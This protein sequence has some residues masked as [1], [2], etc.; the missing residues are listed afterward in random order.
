MATNTVNYAPQGP[1]NTLG[2]YKNYMREFNEKYYA[3]N[4]YMGQTSNIS[5][6]DAAMQG[7]DAAALQAS[8]AYNDRAA[9][10]RDQSAAWMKMLTPVQQSQYWQLNREQKA[11][12]KRYGQLAAA[13][14]FAAIGGLG[15]LGGAGGGA[16]GVGAGGLDTLAGADIAG[17]LIPEFGSSAAYTAGLGGTGAVGGA[18]PWDSFLK[19][20]TSPIGNMATKAGGS[21]L[22]Q[23]I[24]GGGNAYMGNKQAGQY[25]DVISQINQLFAPDS[26]YAKQMQ[27]TLARKD[28]AAGRNSQY[29]DRAVQLA[30]ALTQAKSN[31][32]TSPGYGSLLA[33]RGTN[34]NIPINGLL[35]ILG[36]GAGQDMITQ[37]GSGIG[38]Y[39]KSFFGSEGDKYSPATPN[40]VFD[41][42]WMAAYAPD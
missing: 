39:F 28:A 5:A 2:D 19:T 15:A 42:S 32:L 13:A 33:Q 40:T 6:S 7:N 22:S 24:A 10:D 25:D 14:S 9:Y 41:N 18:A 36:S 29:G 8:N 34:Q 20:L 31:A 4:P 35:A 3:A 1:L 26:P 21:L 17:G 16:G 37:A 27:Q 12:E 38:D 23:L 30:A 11:K